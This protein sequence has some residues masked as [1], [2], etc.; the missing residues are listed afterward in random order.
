[1][2]TTPAFLI[3]VLICAESYT[4][5]YSGIVLFESESKLTR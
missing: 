1:M 2:V 4:E 5:H 3:T